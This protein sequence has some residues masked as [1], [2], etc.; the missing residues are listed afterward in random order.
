[1]LAVESIHSLW[2]SVIAAQL[3]EDRWC[4]RKKLKE[5]SSVL[6]PL[7]G[8]VGGGQNDDKYMEQYGGYW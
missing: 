4:S 1:M 3:D 6:V 7:A 8:C 2:Y 5:E